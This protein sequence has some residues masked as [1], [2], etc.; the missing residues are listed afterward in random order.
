MARLIDGAEE[1]IGVL[2]QAAAHRVAQVEE[3]LQ[4]LQTVIRQCNVCEIGEPDA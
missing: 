3:A 2:D 1:Q 4:D